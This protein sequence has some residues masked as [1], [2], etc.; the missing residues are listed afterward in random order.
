MPQNITINIAGENALIIYFTEEN[1]NQVSDGISA[2][3]QQ[4]EQLIR[5]AMTQDLADDIIDLVPS[6]ASLMVMFNM[7]TTDYHHIRSRLR[8][9]L[10]QID[11]PSGDEVETY[12]DNIVELPVY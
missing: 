1:G 11:Q 12:I 7:M 2:K 6:Y 8:T 9:L 3:V 10:Q 4:V 5:K